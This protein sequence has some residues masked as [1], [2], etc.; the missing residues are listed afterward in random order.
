MGTEWI[1][2]GRSW[3]ELTYEIEELSGLQI[4]YEILVLN[5]RGAKIRTDI[6]R[7]LIGDMSSSG[8]TTPDGYASEMDDLAIVLRYRRLVPEEEL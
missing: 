5:V 8:A 4:E 6:E 7:R 3:R 1:E 2:F